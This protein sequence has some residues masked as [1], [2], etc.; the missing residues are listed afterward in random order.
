MKICAII[1]VNGH[2]YMTTHC[3]LHVL[4]AAFEADIDIHVQVVSNGDNP[5]D[6]TGKRLNEPLNVGINTIYNLVS[7]IHSKAALGYAEAVNTGLEFNKGYDGYLIMNNDAFVSKEYFKRLKLADI[8]A[9]VEGWGPLIYGPMTNQCA[10]IQEWHGL[11]QDVKAVRQLMENKCD[12]H[13]SAPSLFD[14]KPL[15]EK[16]VKNKRPVRR[17]VRWI[18]GFCMYIDSKAFEMVGYFNQ[19]R[20]PMSGEEIDWCLRAEGMGL[21]C[22]ID[23]R[24]FVFHLKGVTCATEFDEEEKKR[25]W[26][27]S[28]DKLREI[29][30]NINQQF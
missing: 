16:V 17:H 30:D 2:E 27:R 14:L 3:I 9:K 25:L 19:Y 24:N 8:E 21:L 29:Y 13:L 15:T 22:T 11:D 23:F 1:P 4:D 5:Y 10:G 7:A 6:V 12:G 18:N 20:F 28:A 26:R